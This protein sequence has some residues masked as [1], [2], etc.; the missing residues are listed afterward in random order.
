MKKLILFI[1]MMS[2]LGLIFAPE[3]INQNSKKIYVVETG[4]SIERISG[5]FKILPWQLR[6]ENGLKP[7]VII[8]PGQILKIPE[9]EWRSYEGNASWYGPGFHGKDMANTKRYNQ[10]K[11]LVAHRYLPLGI[12]VRITNLDTGASIIAPVLDRGPYAIDDN[13]N[14]SREVDLSFG[15]AK[16][17]GVIKPGVIPIRIEP[18]G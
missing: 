15:A 11:I 10:N 17:L 12:N 13:G 6:Q 8:H 5:I 16:L 7:G 1:G 14:Y 3:I 4:D 2:A 9:V 18:L